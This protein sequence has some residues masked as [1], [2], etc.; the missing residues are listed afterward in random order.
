[1]HLIGQPPAFAL[2]ALVTATAVVLAARY[3]AYPIAILGLLG[4]F[5]TPALLTTHVDNE[6]GL[7][8]YVALLNAGVLALAYFKRWRSLNYLAF[9]AT[10]LTFAVWFSE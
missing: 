2:M 5:M 10:W 1:Y 6:I 9:A 3:D 7:F 8:G 4:G